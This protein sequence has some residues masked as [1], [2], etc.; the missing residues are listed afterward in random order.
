MQSI[1]IR[2]QNSKVLLRAPKLEALGLGVQELN[3]PKSR[4]GAF[5]PESQ[6]WAP[7]DAVPEAGVQGTLSPADP[8]TQN[9][10]QTQSS[11]GPRMWG[12]FGAKI[13]VARRGG[14]KGR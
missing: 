14:G 7:G 10:P 5:V 2:S 1:G 8:K 12:L 4:R 3:L 6:G 9:P 13:R 11:Q